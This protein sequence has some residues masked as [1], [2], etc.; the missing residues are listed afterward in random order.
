MM[1]KAISA[2]RDEPWRFLSSE[3]EGRHRLHSNAPTNATARAVLYRVGAS[4]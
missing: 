1:R 2:S 4:A 3:A